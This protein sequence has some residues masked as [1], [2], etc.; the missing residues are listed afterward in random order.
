MPSVRQRIQGFDQEEETKNI[1]TSL[2]GL[3]EKLKLDLEEEDFEELL[4]FNGEKLTNEYLMKLEAQQH[5]K[6]VEEDNTPIPMKK[7][8]TKLLAWG[9]SLI[10][11][12]LAIFEQQAA[13]RRLE[14]KLMMQYNATA[15]FMMRKK[16]N[17]LIVFRSVLSA[18]NLNLQGSCTST[19]YF[20]LH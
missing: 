13:V 7:L 12:A 11:K 8:E 1:L 15:S 4:Y 19:L 20:F 9:F 3:N 6:E 10:D 5:V 2:V 14:I 17:R 18:N 16:E